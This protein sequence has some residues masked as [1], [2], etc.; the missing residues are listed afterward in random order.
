MILIDIGTG[1]A[2]A[3]IAEDGTPAVTFLFETDEEANLGPQTGCIYGRTTL[4]QLVYGINALLTLSSPGEGEEI[5]AI[6]G[7]EKLD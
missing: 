1:V 5:E 7:I 3:W 4:Q 6:P 2:K